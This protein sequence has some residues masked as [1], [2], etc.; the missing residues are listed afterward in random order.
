MPENL[1]VLNL[2]PIQFNYKASSEIQYGLLA[3]Q[4]HETFPYL[5]LYNKTGEPD[6]V[7]YHELCTFLLAEIQRM[8]KRIKALE[9]K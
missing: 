5:C 3:E 2:R 8:D 4:V 7:K 6:S 1:S 9:S